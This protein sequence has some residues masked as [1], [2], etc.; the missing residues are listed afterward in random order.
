MTTDT[1]A[2]L[3]PAAPAA[4]EP[5]QEIEADAVQ[6]M[7]PARDPLPEL[8]QHRRLGAPSKVWR[9]PNASG[10]LLFAVA[11]FD[12]PNGD[13][14]VLPYTCGPDSWVFKAPQ[15]PRALY[16]L[17]LHAA[18]PEAPVL[19]VEGEK[20]ADAA[21]T[22]FPDWVP[23]TWQGGSNAVNKSDHSPLRGRRVV[24]IPDNDE[25]GRK[26]AAAMARAA[27]Q[28]GAASVGIVE[29]PTD[30]PAGRGLSRADGE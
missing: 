26:A 20:A 16:N 30:W 11:R 28:A 25:P 4:A 13:K 27:K 29:V 24:I 6:P 10:E 1:F 14:Q 17:D 15:P 3:P 21:A 12:Q 9:Y 18:R 8:I 5:I 7:Q 22:M 23:M 2:P 19:I